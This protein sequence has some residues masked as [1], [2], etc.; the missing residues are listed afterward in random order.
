M[1]KKELLGEI[2]VCVAFPV[3]LFVSL[4]FCAVVWG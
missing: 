4:L 3:S 2:A 1:K